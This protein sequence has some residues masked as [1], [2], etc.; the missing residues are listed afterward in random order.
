MTMFPL[1]GCSLLRFGQK[2][3]PAGIP[4]GGTSSESFDYI[5]DFMEFVNSDI[6][7]G[8]ENYKPSESTHLVFAGY[9]ETD[10]YPSICSCEVQEVK[11]G[12]LCWSNFLMSNNFNI[13]NDSNR[14]LIK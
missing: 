11:N 2:K 5:E 9:G 3:P 10:S 12:K 13:Y 14:V 7:T 1:I 4:A 8:S 6:L